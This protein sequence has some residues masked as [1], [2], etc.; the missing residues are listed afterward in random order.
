MPRL[1]TR[2][3]PSRTSGRERVFTNDDERLRSAAPIRRDAP[4][5]ALVLPSPSVG[6]RP[7]ERVNPLAPSGAHAGEAREC[8]STAS[9]IDS[10]SARAR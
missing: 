2:H 3:S 4:A 9:R 7:A 5:G 1:S 8:R 10:F 6:A